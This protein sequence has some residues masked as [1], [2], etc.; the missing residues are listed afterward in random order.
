MM[1]FWR[2]DH[3]KD[4]FVQIWT[5]MSP[6]MANK[7]WKFMHERVKRSFTF[8]LPVYSNINHKQELSWNHFLSSYIGP[9]PE[10]VLTFW[11]FL[12]IFC[13]FS[14]F[15]DIVRH[16][17]TLFQHF[18]NFLDFFG[19]FWH[20]STFFVCQKMLKNVEKSL[21]RRNM[22]HQRV[23]I[24]WSSESVFCCLIPYIIFQ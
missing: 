13:Q 12:D 22:W 9:L 2:S 6:K 1:K 7:I 18:Y 15:F 4:I 11:K 14:T 19:L 3:L 23:S 17:L 8:S 10:L 21:S 24:T 20:F 16:F 5:M